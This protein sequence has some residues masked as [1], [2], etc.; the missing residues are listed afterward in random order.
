M[1][2][3]CMLR[4]LATVGQAPNEGHGHETDL[5]RRMR[6]PK[7]QPRRD[8][9]SLVNQR[10][11]PLPSPSPPDNFSTPQSQLH[12]PSPIKWPDFGELAGHGVVLFVPG[13]ALQSRQDVDGAI[14]EPQPTANWL[15]SRR[16]P[17]PLSRHPQ[18]GQLRAMRFKVQTTARSRRRR[19]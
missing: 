3:L 9:Q 16:H 14:R 19:W 5:Q 2:R 4:I 1:T 17:L 6:R 15:A 18:Y 13:C 12:V 7:Q 8:G 11:P 10:A